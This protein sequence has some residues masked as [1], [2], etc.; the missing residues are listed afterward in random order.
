MVNDGCWMLLMVLLVRLLV[1]LVRLLVIVSNR[2]DISRSWSQPLR[3]AE[4][5]LKTLTP[6]SPGSTFPVLWRRRSSR[7]LDSFQYRFP[8][9][10]TRVKSDWIV[11][12]Q[13]ESWA[14]NGDNYRTISQNNHQPLRLGSIDWG[15]FPY[16]KIWW[17]QFEILAWNNCIGAILWHLY[18]GSTVEDCPRYRS[19]KMDEYGR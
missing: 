5:G 1:N 11:V 14:I 6:S 15:R 2:W 19:L 18:N 3:P 4:P 8:L 17:E 10:W 9:T 12:I 16:A 13:C 7:S